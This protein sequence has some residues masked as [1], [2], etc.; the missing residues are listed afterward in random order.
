MGTN[1]TSTSD[2][3][4]GHNLAGLRVSVD[5][6]APETLKPAPRKLRRRSPRQLKRLVRSIEEFGFLV[7]VLVD[8]ELEI[9]A[10][11]GRV[12]AAKLIGLSAIPII[13]VEHLTEAQRRLFT[14]ADNVAPQGVEWEQG[15]LTLELRE[16][17]L[18]EPTLDL[19]SSGLSIVEI[20]TM[21]GRARTQDLADA[22]DALPQVESE[23]VS[24]VGDRW[25]LGRHILGCGDARD[26]AFVASLLEG[27]QAR[28]FL[29]D[30]PWN[31]KIE[32]VV[33]GKG[34]TKHVDF[35]MGAGEMTR[36]EFIVFL[37]ASIEAAQSIL[38]DGA[39]VYMFMDW[40]NLDALAEAAI[41]RGLVQKNLLIW[42][43][44]NAG[45]GQLYRSQHE[46]IAL[47]KHGEA[48][49][50]NN[51]RM[52]QDGR[53]RSNLMF[54]PGANSF[55]KGRDEALASHPT[56]KPVSILA[57]I[58]LDV[59]APGEIVIDTFGGSGSTLIAAERMDRTCCMAELHPPY[60]DGIIRR[61]EALFGTAAV[62]VDTGQTFAQVTAERL[63]CSAILPEAGHE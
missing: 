59:T 43:K 26:A 31:L 44:D 61:F 23:P 54:Y 27:Q 55:G 33:S 34:K 45:L 11:E 38:V 21:F 50:I 30:S 19:T 22:D 42:C 36:A 57:D 1:A 58:I 48:A 9:V 7:P 4:R 52:G 3:R 14:I 29:T 53:N 6:V 60:V 37:A 46:L 56:S 12:E 16:L 24:R 62:H 5:Y 8:E 20:D 35:V 10:G 40:R 13:R 63:A 41:V 17:Q 15:A 32:G 49:H 51:V 47:Y 39:L 28:L 18:L 2:A 25:R